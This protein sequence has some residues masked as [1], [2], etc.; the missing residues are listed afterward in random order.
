MTRYHSY[1]TVAEITVIAFQRKRIEVEMEKETSAILILTPI[2]LISGH[3][4]FDMKRI[5]HITGSNYP[6]ELEPLKL[7][8]SL[9]L[10]F[11][12]I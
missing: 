8:V 5:K 3:L 12:M 6:N 10:H 1:S 7:E 4:D 11:L 2:K 9:S